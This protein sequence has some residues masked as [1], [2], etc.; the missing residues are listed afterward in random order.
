MFIGAMDGGFLYEN[1]V[2]SSDKLR[3]SEITIFRYTSDE[4]KMS[5]GSI[6]VVK[7]RRMVKSDTVLL[8]RNVSSRCLFTHTSVTF[9]DGP[10]LSGIALV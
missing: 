8:S 2:M 4:A 9:D 5:S 7:R 6:T 10:C 1:G 3:S